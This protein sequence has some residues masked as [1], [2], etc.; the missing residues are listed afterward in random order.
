MHTGHCTRKTKA[1]PPGT[2]G[3]G[4]PCWASAGLWDGLFTSWCWL[5]L[6]IPPGAAG[7]T[8]PVMETRPDFE[9]KAAAWGI[10]L[11]QLLSASR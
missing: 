4:D 3:E 7:A 5:S 6:P 9:Q 11:C 10:L 8:L 1:I 2:Q